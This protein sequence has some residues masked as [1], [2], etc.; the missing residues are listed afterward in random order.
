MFIENGGVAV[1]L[2]EYCNANNFDITIFGTAS[3][4]NIYAGGD[5]EGNKW[6]GIFQSCSYIK[7][8]HSDAQVVTGYIED[9]NL[10]GKWIIDNAVV[11]GAADMRTRADKIKLEKRVSTGYSLGSS[12]STSYLPMSDQFFGVNQYD[13]RWMVAPNPNKVNI[14]ADVD[15]VSITGLVF[16]RTG[17]AGAYGSHLIIPAGA[18]DALIKAHGAVTVSFDAKNY[19]NVSGVVE[20]GSNSYFIPKCQ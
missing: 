15:N 8:Q 7:N 17:G 5:C 14:V 6:T 18:V 10:S 16:K 11:N 2:N 20:V 13:E 4:L 12:D 3:Y 19:N 1:N 9:C